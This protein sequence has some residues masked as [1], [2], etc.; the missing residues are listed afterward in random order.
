MPVGHCCSATGFAAA[1]A[2]I[3]PLGG[4]MGNPNSST[5]SLAAG[6]PR[7]CSCSAE[8]KSMA[9][10]KKGSGNSKSIMHATKSESQISMKLGDNTQ[11][12]TPPPF[13]CVQPIINHS[14]TYVQAAGSRASRH[15]SLRPAQC[16]RLARRLTF[17]TL[18]PGRTHPLRQAAC[19][20]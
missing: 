6:S 19:R 2:A 7:H 12:D 16:P 1:G 5:W 11:A 18:H 8:A 17:L 15:P 20:T 4:A 10:D 9:W 3:P 14:I 13:K